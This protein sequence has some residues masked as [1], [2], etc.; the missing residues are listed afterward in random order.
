MHFCP[1][2][3][4]ELTSFFSLSRTGWRFHLGEVFTCR[5]LYYGLSGGGLLQRL[6]DGT[7]GADGDCRKDHLLTVNDADSDG[8]RIVEVVD[9]Q[10]TDTV[11]KADPQ[12]HHNDIPEDFLYS[13]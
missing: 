4:P 13:T 3:I 7:H 6:P 12:R 1:W 2:K 11:D 10:T 9:R 5:R 8:N